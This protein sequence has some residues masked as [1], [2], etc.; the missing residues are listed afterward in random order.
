MIILCNECWKKFDAD[1]RPM[2]CPYCG[3]TDGFAQIKITDKS[4][5]ELTYK[6]HIEK[7]RKY[8]L[9]HPPRGIS[10]KE[11]QDMPANVLDDMADIWSEF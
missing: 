3:A 11:I 4:G 7:L 6:E 10:L 2:V 1:G 5:R 8:Y 9:A